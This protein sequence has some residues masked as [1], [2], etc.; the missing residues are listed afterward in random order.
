[1]QSS[2]DNRSRAEHQSIDEQ[3]E[4]LYDKLIA[5]A[6]QQPAED[7]LPPDEEIERYY[8]RLLELQTAAAERFR[9]Q[10]EASLAMP[11][12]AGANVLARIRAL[13][14]ELEDLASSDA[15]PSVSGRRLDHP[16]RFRSQLSA[17][18]PGRRQRPGAATQKGMS[19][20]LSNNTGQSTGYRVVGGGQGPVPGKGGGAKAKALKMRTLH[21]G[22][23]EPKTYVTLPVSVPV[24]EVHFHH[25][26]AVFAKLKIP[27]G[28]GEE[29]QVALVPNG[30]GTPKPFVCR[31]KA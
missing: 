4:H 7:G 16:S 24:C 28:G 8:D 20:C 12:D 26:G 14:G 27:S 11:I 19:L 22:T 30:K 1:M 3:I 6:Q 13:K 5:L 21:E 23:L 18:G 29:V 17:A 25:D 9:K 10:F 2:D 31:R 15:T